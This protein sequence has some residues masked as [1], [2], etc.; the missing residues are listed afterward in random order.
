MPEKFSPF[1][2]HLKSANKD[3]KE[4]SVKEF[5]APAEKK[6]RLSVVK[7]IIFNDATPPPSNFK[8]SHELLI[9]G[10]LQRFLPQTEFVIGQTE[11]GQKALFIAQEKIEGQTLEEN[12]KLTENQKKELQRLYALSLKM[13]LATIGS[14]KTV[15]FTISTDFYEKGYT[16]PHKED[17]L[18]PEI[19]KES[20]ILVGKKATDKVAH[21]YL[22]DNHSLISFRQ[23]EMRE[24]SYGLSLLKDFVRHRSS[25]LYKE[26]SKNQLHRL[27]LDI[28]KKLRNHEPTE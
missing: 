12:P 19:F 24:N 7:E 10:G 4:T 5:Q 17:G 22:V 3:S 8:R 15:D 2:H 16:K 1:A 6:P 27:Y 13:L 14:E 21:V 28:Q 25:G 9:A 18:M 11:S 20:N 26:N 23:D